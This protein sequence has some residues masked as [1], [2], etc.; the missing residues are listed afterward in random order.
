MA[1]PENS[2]Q[3][4]LPDFS[5]TSVKA[6][7]DISLRIL[8]TSNISGKKSPEI[9]KPP[10]IGDI[11]IDALRGYLGVFDDA[12]PDIR[13]KEFEGETA[14]GERYRLVLGS[15]QIVKEIQFRIEQETRLSESIKP[16][17]QTQKKK[18]KRPSGIHSP[19]DGSY[20]MQSANREGYKKSRSKR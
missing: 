7:L 13:V 6:P 20:F 16:K 5:S 14:H 11:P 9:K 4:S 3:L 10:T 1:H 15:H 19:I 2:G 12:S 8:P 18:R 17:E